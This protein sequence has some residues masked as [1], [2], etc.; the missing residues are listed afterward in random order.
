MSPEA[1]GT[2]YPPSEAATMLALRLAARH[3]TPEAA[4]KA[5]QQTINVIEKMRIPV[6]SGSQT[7]VASRAMTLL[8]FWAQWE[9]EQ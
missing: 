2:F 6:T 5:L 9:V 4:M 3:R 8:K 7:W 1:L